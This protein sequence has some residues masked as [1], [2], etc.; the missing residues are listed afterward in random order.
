M[1]PTQKPVRVETAKVTVFTC[2]VCQEAVTGA[3]EVAVR[4]GKVDLSN[5][6][7]DGGD[8]VT[9]EASATATTEMRGLDVRHRCSNVVSVYPTRDQ[10]VEG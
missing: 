5:I 10:A 9:L 7:E 6:I 3:V 2:P 8:Q 1:N 4:L